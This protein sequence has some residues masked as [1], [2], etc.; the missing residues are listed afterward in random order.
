MIA[1]AS[2]HFRRGITRASTG[3]LQSVLLLLVGI[4]QAEVHD[5]DVHVF[6]EQKVLG[7]QIAVTHLNLVQVFNTGENLMEESAGF[8]V[9]QPALFYYVFE[10]FPTACILHYQKELL[11]GLNYLI[12]LHDIWMPNDFQNVDLS[13]HSCYIGLV[14]YFIFFKDFNGD[15]LRGQLVYSF[16]HFAERTRANCLACQLI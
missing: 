1:L 15:L 16:A 12:Q 4:A 7:L 2:D 10:Q 6:V 8:A 9:L 13:H 11:R 3:C 14:L 5:L